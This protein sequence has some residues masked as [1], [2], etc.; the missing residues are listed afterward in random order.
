MLILGGAF[1]AACAGTPDFP[2]A[3]A[4]EETV[5]E[6]SSPLGGT[7]LAQR[8]RE[9]ERA[10]RDMVHHRATLVNLRQRG[11][12]NGMIL[13]SQFLDAYVTRHLGPL[14]RSQWQ[15]RH[16]ELM[17]LDASLRLLRADAFVQMRSPGRVQEELDEIDRRFAGRDNLLVDYPVGE[18]GTLASAIESLRKRKWRG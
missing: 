4:G 10:Y 2:N 1:L 8:R 12:R 13:F 16:A 15:S 9:M 14:L 3:F 5:Q 6:Q 18:Q 11:D 7:A 17:A